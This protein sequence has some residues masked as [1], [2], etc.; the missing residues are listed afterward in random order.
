MI[1][2]FT[3]LMPHKTFKGHGLR[4]DLAMALKNTNA[5]VIR[6]LGGCVVEGINEPNALRFSRTIGL[7][8]E[9]PSSQLMWHYRTTNGLG[10]HEY[11]QL[12]GDERRRAGV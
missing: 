6:F 3:S 11:L 4:E 12:C 10:F 5:Q 1:I 9:R 2:G 8:W 7:V